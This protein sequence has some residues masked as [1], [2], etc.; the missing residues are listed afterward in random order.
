MLTTIKDTI[1]SK[2]NHNVIVWRDLIGTVK[3]K[4][5][6]LADRT[7]VTKRTIDYYTSIGLLKAERS[8]SNYRYYNQISI[9]RLNLIEKF[10]RDGMSLNEIKKQIIAMDSEEIDVLEL[11][12]KIQCLDKDVAKI[13]SQ[14]DN[15]NLDNHDFVKRNI[16]KE[17]MSLIQT[18]LLLL[19]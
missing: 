17:S 2:V 19:N 4:I 16:T 13:L 8:S 10:K 18:L 7:N 1:L 15:K 6:E 9:E 11:R 12:L 3:L 14:I 5:G